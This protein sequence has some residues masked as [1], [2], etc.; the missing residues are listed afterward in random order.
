MMTLMSGDIAGRIVMTDHSKDPRTFPHNNPQDPFL[1]G[2]DRP[3]LRIDPFIY[4]VDTNGTIILNNRNQ[5]PLKKQ[6]DQSLLAYEHSIQKLTLNQEA[7]Y[8]VKSPIEMDEEIIGWVVMVDSK[9]NLSRVNQ[10]YT[11]LAIMVISLALLGWGAIY[12]L[13]SRLTKPIK[14]M[15]KA[16]KHIANGD[17]QI[18]LANKGHEKEVY[19]LTQSFMEMSNKLERLESLRTELLAG[20]THELKTPITSISGL[21]QAIKDDVVTKEEAQEFLKL[22]LNETDKMKKMVDDLLAFNQFAAN[23]VEVNKASHDINDLIEDAVD[24]WKIPQENSQIKV[25]LNCLNYPVD[26]NVDPIR[27]QQ[28]MTNLLNNAKN[29]MNQGEE[30][31]INIQEDAKMVMIDVEDRG[32]GIPEEEQ[33]FIFER[34]YRGEGKKYHV[35]GLGLGLPLS[36]MISQALGGDLKLLCSS[37]KG[38]TFRISLPKNSDQ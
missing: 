5:G 37:P 13:T 36:K 34:F 6:I 20:V 35:R 10:E 18:E 24:S 17:Y 2:A 15:A 19:E 26:V 4:L 16:A 30:V 28:I 21:L 14:D 25:N 3:D 22:S 33:A 31:N 38:T 29:A 27:F 23:A 8:L 7:F 32:K 9:Q 12:I 11:L 1:E